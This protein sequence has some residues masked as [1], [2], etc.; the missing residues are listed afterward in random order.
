MASIAG[1]VGSIG[2]V[3]ERRDA[4]VTSWLAVVAALVFAIVVVGGGTR[5]TESGLSIT[6]WELVT[7]VLPPLTESQ[8]LAE[9]EKYR[10]IPQYAALH[11]GMSLAEFQTI[12]LWEWGHRL[13]GRVIGAAMAGKISA[14]RLFVIPIRYMN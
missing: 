2:A 10:Q 9:F 5:L 11:R 3:A 6:E 7:G 13:L 8:W 4:L 12:Y 1:R 14:R